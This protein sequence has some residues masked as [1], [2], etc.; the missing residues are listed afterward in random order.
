MAWTPLGRIMQATGGALG[1][2]HAMLP[3]PLLMDD[4]L[5][6]FF[7]MCDADLRGRT[8]FADLSLEFPHPVMSVE[9]RPVFDLGPAGAFDC[10]GVNPL[11]VLRRGDR[12]LMLY[13][14]W[15]RDVDGAPYTLFTGLAE[16][17]DEGLS[18][19]RLRAPLLPPSPAERWFRT[20]AFAWPEGEEWRL[21]YI[22]GGRFIPGPGK[23][24]PIYSL[25]AARSPALEAWPAEGEELLA[26][27]AGAG[28]LGYG[29]PAVWRDGAEETLLISRRT[30]DGYEL[31]QT[32]L[33][34]ALKGQADFRPVLTH[35]REDWERQMTCFGMP[36]R[37]G[38]RE[39]LFY[40]G[41]GFGRSGFGAAWRPAQERLQRI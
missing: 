22:A 2:S 13:V 21:L 19:E 36:V 16:S 15:R 27:D 9:E 38:D 40:N 26:P 28:E 10:D 30:M 5:R 24:L 25:K 18:F 41:D 29:R 33:A 14:G 20:A 4:R 17:R 12:L 8:F 39:L 11:Q 7:A 32:P 35:P 1:R 37:M 34:G 31:L 6:V 23:A 3:T